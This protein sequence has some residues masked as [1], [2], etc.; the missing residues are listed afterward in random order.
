VAANGISSDKK[1]ELQIHG[2]RT[3]TLASPTCMCAS[4]GAA[5]EYV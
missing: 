3:R 1:K 2:S 5:A 4:H